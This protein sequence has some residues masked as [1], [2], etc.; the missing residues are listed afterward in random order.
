MQKLTELGN[1]QAALERY[2]K[3]RKLSFTKRA[4]LPRLTDIL[5]QDL[6]RND[7]LEE[8]D[9]Y[10]LLIEFKKL[11]ELQTE[12]INQRAKRFGQ[13]RKILSERFGPDSPL[14]KFSFTQ[15]ITREQLHQIE[16]NKDAHVE[17]RRRD[18][19]QLN[20][21]DI[22]FLM[23]GCLSS[24]D[25]YD[26]IIAV[27]LASGS[28]MIEVLNKNVSTFMSVE[29]DPHKI[30][31]I[32]LAKTKIE[33]TLIRPLLWITSD[34]FLKTLTEVRTA[35]DDISNL[36]ND[37]MG[38]VVE[39][40]LNKRIKS[41]GVGITSSHGLRKAYVAL[42]YN[43]LPNEE[44]N[45]ISFAQFTQDILGQVDIKHALNYTNVNVIEAPKEEKKEA[46]VEVEEK[47]VQKPSKVVLLTRDGREI[48]FPRKQPDKTTTSTLP[49]L[50]ST[51]ERLADMNIKITS[52][53]MKR[54]GF[55]STVLLNEQYKTLR[56]TL[57]LKLSINV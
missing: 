5:F 3:S 41:W 14:V 47:K 56:D 27:M 26:K 54:I 2:L 49:Q 36:S 42:E 12:N 9:G 7:P 52:T 30:K 43:L 50:L 15:S 19:I 21:T 51:C 38:R 45:K 29:G 31:I 18:R 4:K 25:I 44:R 1:N 40:P 28:R 17:D 34:V 32:G 24:T 10:I 53:I 13:I 33:R 46:P 39:T 6:A 22:R 16:K 35:L 48:V 55:N 11:V 57:N 20:E 23:T 8:K 37:K